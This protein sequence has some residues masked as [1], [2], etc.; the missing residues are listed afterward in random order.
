M[1][2]QTRRNFSAEFKAKVAIE[3]LKEQQT[4]SELATKYELHP[5][6]I[7][8]WKK[9]LLGGSCAVFE[10]GRQPAVPAGDD[11]E[12]DALYKAV[13]QLKIENDWLKKK[14]DQIFGKGWKN[15]FNK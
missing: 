5:V 15:G 3:A 7:T 1:S 9:Q 12:K 4:L 6:Q 13:G 14:S 11:P 10:G 8:D 2:K